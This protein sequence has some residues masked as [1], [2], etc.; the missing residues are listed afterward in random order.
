MQDILYKKHE[1]FL[2]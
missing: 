2:K 1:S